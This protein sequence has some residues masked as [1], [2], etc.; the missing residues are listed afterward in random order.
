MWSLW[1]LRVIFTPL[2]RSQRRHDHSSEK[3]GAGR[4]SSLRRNREDPLHH[5]VQPLQDFGVREAQ[6][7]KS[8]CL[9][10]FVEI[11]DPWNT[12]TVTREILTVIGARAR[13]GV[14]ETTA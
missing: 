4:I 8:L 13:N 14:E 7:E 2:G 10:A 9:E 11:R 1:P 5:R 12:Q 3:G 6:H